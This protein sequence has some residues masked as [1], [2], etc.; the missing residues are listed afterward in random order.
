MLECLIIIL[1]IAGVLVCMLGAALVH[2][3]V[4]VAISVRRS[5][6]CDHVGTYHYTY[7]HR[8]PDT[9]RVIR[10]TTC[11]SC[12]AVLHYSNEWEN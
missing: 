6:N 1:K 7:V 11:R 9:G 3:A 10:E 8:D 12:D 4:K 5:R 2:L